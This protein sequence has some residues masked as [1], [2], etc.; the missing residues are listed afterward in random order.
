MNK[1]ISSSNPRIEEVDYLQVDNLI[2]NG[3]QLSGVIL[4]N[5]TIDANVNTITNIDHN[6]LLNIGVNSHQAIDTH[7]AS[8]E[9]VH[10]LDNVFL[11]NN[12]VVGTKEPQV[13][14]NKTL[15]NPKIDSFL[16]FRSGSEQVIFQPSYTIGSVATFLTRNTVGANPTHYFVTEDQS[17]TLTN[18]TIDATLNTLLNLP[19]P[20]RTIWRISPASDFENITS[21]YPTYQYMTF[22]GYSAQL[23]EYNTNVSWISIVNKIRIDNNESFDL[24]MRISPWFKWH[25]YSSAGIWMRYFVSTSQTANYGGTATILGV[26]RELFDSGGHTFSDDQIVTLPANS[27]LWIR[28]EMALRGSS[29]LTRL[30]NMSYYTLDLWK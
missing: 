21:A 5:S 17:Q 2:S 12:K 26:E 1:F 24:K 27:S 18:K 15:V 3:G 13:L 4:S 20:K 19:N 29:S 28:V 14:E 9:G 6:N 7:I 16:D 23:N 30:R 8:D 22:N 11:T 10:G 25:L